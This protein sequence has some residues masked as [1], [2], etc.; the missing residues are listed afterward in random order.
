[1]SFFVDNDAICITKGDD[2]V[3][4]VSEILTGSGEEYVLQE[5]DVLTL[6][7]RKMPKA[8]DPILLQ[9][10]SSPGQKRIVFRHED[11]SELEV[12]RYSADIQ[13]TSFDGKRYTIWP[14]LTGSGR[15]T[16]KNL[17]NFVIMPE[18]TTK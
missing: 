12:G 1:M 13:L 2:A 5:N 18:V 9:I 8:D 7:V 10:D 14:E 3:M 17:S 11:T 16:I 15:Y 4:E 6:T